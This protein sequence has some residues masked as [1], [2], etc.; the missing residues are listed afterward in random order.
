[1]ETCD[2]ASDELHVLANISQRK[3]ELQIGYTSKQIGKRLVSS[4]RTNHGSS[5]RGLI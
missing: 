1:M 3:L 2:L 4:P 5:W